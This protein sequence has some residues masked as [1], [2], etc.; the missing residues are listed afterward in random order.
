MVVLGRKGENV[1]Q[2]G[3]SGGSR[4]QNDVSDPGLFFT[5]LSIHHEMSNSLLICPP[6]MAFCLTTGSIQVFCFDLTP[7]E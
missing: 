6:T 5:L 4:S 3:P 7:L 2:W 1:R